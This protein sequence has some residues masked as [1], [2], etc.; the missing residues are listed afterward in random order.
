MTGDRHRRAA[1]PAAVVAGPAGETAGPGP[2]VRVRHHPVRRS[3]TLGHAAA[4]AWVDT[5][6]RALRFPRSGTGG[7][8]ERHRRGASASTRRRAARERPTTRS[9]DPAVPVRAGHG[10]AKRPRPGTS[11]GPVVM[12]SGWPGLTS[13][14]CRTRARPTP[15]RGASTSAAATSTAG[16]ERSEALRL[17]PGSGRPDDPAKDDPLDT[18]IWQASEAGRPA[19]PLGPARPGWHAECAAMAMSVFGPAVNVPRRR[20]GPAGSPTTP[21]TRPWPRRSPASGRTRAPGCTR[22]RSPSARRSPVRRQPGAARRT[23]RRAI[24][25]RRLR[26]MILDRPWVESWDYQPELLDAAAARLESLLPGGRAH[27]GQRP[28][29]GGRDRGGCW[30]PDFDVP[31]ALD[32]AI[33]TGGGPARALASVLGLS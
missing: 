19:C 24:R 29:S 2:R 20:R 14:A 25:R 17:S 30:P 33:E 31:A 32:L 1:R 5:L 11:H 7:V 8:P 18:A 21:T 6:G 16:L 28:G 27:R 9:G 12:W 23:A 13:G 4:F 3:R 10:R 15:A 26:L 22:G